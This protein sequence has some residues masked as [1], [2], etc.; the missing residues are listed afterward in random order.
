M[1]RFDDVAVRADGEDC[2]LIHQVLQSSAGEARR[3]RGHHVQVHIGAERLVARVD[4][5]NRHAALLVWSVHGHAAVEAARAQ[6]GRIEDVSAVRRGEDDDASVAAEAVHFREDLVERLL[7]LIVR[8]E[9]AAT[10][11]LAANG[12][13]L[14]DEDDARRVL[15]R[16]GEQRADARR[17]DADEHFHELGARRGDEGHARLAGARASEQRLARARGALEEHAARGLGADL[18]VLFRELEELDDLGQFELGRVA[19]RHVG[20]G[21]ARLRLHLDLG[22][23]VE[24]AHGA[25]AT[26]AAHAAHAAAAAVEE[27][28][29]AEEQKREDEVADDRPDAVQ[30][31]L[32][33]RLDGEL[34]VVLAQAGEDL[35]ALGGEDLHAVATAVR[36]DG[37][38][39]AARV[40]E[41]DTLHG[42][43]LNRV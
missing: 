41:R 4:F 31:V 19:T 13:N 23:R 14:V 37:H 24:H 27:E 36:I 3:A 35:G 32:R 25:A 38:E 29:A 16:V 33:G 42:V 43:L 34:D 7:A 1:R 18:G 21:D 26:A 5:E 8:R 15:L 28:E 6:E 22:L 12:V 9:A 17:A 40:V 11:A 2:C 10:R 39:C 30:G 20:K